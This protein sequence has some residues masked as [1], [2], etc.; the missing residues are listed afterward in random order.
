VIRKIVSILILVCLVLS[1]TPY[2]VAVETV[3]ALRSDASVTVND[4]RMPLRAYNISGRLYVDLLEVA[5]VLSGT[6]NQ[7]TYRWSER[8][9]TVNISTG[10]AFSAIGFNTSR[11]IA[12]ARQATPAEINFLVDGDELPISA[13]S[14]S[15]ETYFDLRTIAV[16]MDFCVVWDPFEKSLEIDTRRSNTDSVTVK[17]ID[18]DKPMIALTFDDGP[19][20]YTPPILDALEKHNAVATF[21]VTGS[22]VRTYSDTVIRAF[23]GGNEISNHSWS[24]PRLDRSSEQRIRSELQN[25]NDAIEELTGVAP[26]NMRPPYGA[27]NQ[28]AKTISEELGL[29][30][31]M[32]SLDP[33]DWRY[34]NA[35]YIYNYV[36]TN[37]KDRDVIL[38]HDLY[39][40]TAAAAE[41]LIPALIAEGYQLVTLSELFYYSDITL[42]PGVAY[43]NAVP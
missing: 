27:M 30:I 23:E 17:R 37:V 18:P 34:R 4:V 13:F 3:E 26:T 22:R 19:S 6:E 32:W 40:S 21:Y 15:G 9:R 33:F 43:R 8:N 25:T 24:H 42:E 35:N 20:I 5:V 28:R 14:I 2:A 10:R 1:I 41:R 11:R 36:M 38:F 7:F 16:I 31:I 29:S 12:N 39:E